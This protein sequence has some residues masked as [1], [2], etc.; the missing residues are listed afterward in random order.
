[1]VLK[2]EDKK[3]I[4]S[5]VASV[6]KQA[7]SLVA[8]EYSGLTVAQLT[9]L[10]KSARHSGVHIRVV[11]NTLA[12]RALE[13]TQFA[14]MQ[15]ELVGPLI[16]AFSTEDPGAAARLIKEFVKD[17]EKL[18]VKA[19]AIENQLLPPE[20]LQQLAS[21]PTRDEGIAQLMSVMKAPIT[22]LVRTMA[23]PHAKLVR[24]FAAIRDAKSKQAES[25]A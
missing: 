20:G 18:K 22:K 11:R 14:C 7:L 10:R 15:P 23:E 2:L 21:L 24:T 3:T 9:R 19:L 5:E 16:L 1:M 13:G 17:N 8:A 6:A 25:A 4:V 12:R